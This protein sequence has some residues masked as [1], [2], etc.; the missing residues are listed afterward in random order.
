MCICQVPEEP[1]PKEADTKAQWQFCF[2]AIQF[3]DIPLQVSLC[4]SELRKRRPKLLQTQWL[5]PLGS[6]ICRET[7]RD[8]CIPVVAAAFVA[9][10]FLGVFVEVLFLPQRDGLPLVQLAAL[11][12]RTCP[13]GAW[14]ESI[15]QDCEGGWARLQPDGSCKC[16]QC[17]SFIFCLF[18]CI[19]L[20]LVSCARLCCKDMRYNMVQAWATAY[21]SCNFS[22]PCLDFHTFCNLLKG[23]WDVCNRPTKP[24]AI[25]IFDGFLVCLGCPAGSYW[26]FWTL[27]FLEYWG[28]TFFA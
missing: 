3:V 4:P 6:E 2:V 23:P 14:W 19:W 10:G 15:A 1:L 22:K 17:S 12:S 7:Y 26:R 25:W 20:F 21:K 9:Q 18:G 28:F 13:I 11:D 8:A 5:T 27:G 24:A 16:E